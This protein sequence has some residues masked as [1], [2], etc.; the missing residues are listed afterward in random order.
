MPQS[1]SFFVGILIVQDADFAELLL[2]VPEADRIGHVFNPLNPLTG[3]RMTRDHVTRTVTKIGKA[4]GVV[5]ERKA[6]AASVERK[7]EA[8]GEVAKRTGDTIRYASAHDLRRTFGSRW[9]KRVMPAVLQ[10]LMRHETINTTLGYYV[11]LD[12]DN[13]AEDLWR[14]HKTA[15]SGIISGI[16]Q[17]ANEN[18][19]QDALDV[20]SHGNES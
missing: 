9:A 12:A 18:E 6:A 17:P 20:N 15:D 14:T 5:V 11:D 4:A 19:R 2:T 16:T 1:S 8:A 7:A 13:L 3:K 10:K